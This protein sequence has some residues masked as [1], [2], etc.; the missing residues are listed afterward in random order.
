MLELYK[1]IKNNP[2]F[3]G[4][5]DNNIYKIIGCFSAYEKKF[6][7]GEIILSAGDV[8]EKIGMVTKG[9]VYL[10]SED[11]NGNRTIMSVLSEGDLLAESFAFKA[12]GKKALPV[13]VYAETDCTLLFFDYNKILNTCANACSCHIQFIENMLALVSQKNIILNRRL[14]HLTKRSTKEKLLSYLY[15][16]ALLSGK[17]NFTIPFNRQQLADYLCVE[18]SAM[19]AV[20]SSL[21]K[22]GKIDFNKN[23]FVICDFSDDNF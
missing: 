18:R 5:D 22:S 9:C 17:N 7:K 6:S 15:E 12:T 21:K 19:S 11:Y 4:I 10:I 23:H 2:L 14:V 13:S 20:M 8:I 3:N 16:Q 1:K